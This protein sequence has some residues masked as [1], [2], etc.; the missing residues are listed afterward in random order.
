[1]ILIL[2]DGSKS[3][4]IAVDNFCFPLSAFMRIARMTLL[5]TAP[6]K[7]KST[8]AHCSKS[9]DT[10]HCRTATPTHPDLFYAG[11]RDPPP[12]FNLSF[13]GLSFID[14]FL[15]QRPWV[16]FKGSKRHP[17]GPAQEGAYCRR[18]SIVSYKWNVQEPLALSG[19]FYGLGAPLMGGNDDS[20][21]HRSVISTIAAKALS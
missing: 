9:Q 5:F 7:L 20:A 14:D 18:V 16:L 6:A 8:C 11:T 21:G 13:Q 12:L 3:I 15:G 17:D 4:Q 19:L 2:E 10:T 1:M